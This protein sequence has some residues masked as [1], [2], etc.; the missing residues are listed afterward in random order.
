M[1]FRFFFLDLWCA[2][3]AKFVIKITHLYKKYIIQIIIIIFVNM[4]NSYSGRIFFYIKL[5]KKIVGR[6]SS[7]TVANNKIQI[8]LHIPQVQAISTPNES[9]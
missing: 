3:D 4:K 5:H 2:T 7:N 9:N 8:I 6:I 1:T